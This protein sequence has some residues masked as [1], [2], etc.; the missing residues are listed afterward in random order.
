MNAVAVKY[1]TTVPSRG[2]TSP[3]YFAADHAAS[4]FHVLYDDVRL[5]ADM[6]ADMAREQPPLGVGGAAGRE[7]DQHREP[8][9]L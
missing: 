3:I 4:T 2:A 5:A 7:V 8:L 1:P 9:P 6:P